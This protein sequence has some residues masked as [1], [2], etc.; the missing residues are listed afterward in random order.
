MALSHSDPLVQ[1]HRPKFLIITK[2]KHMNFKHLENYIHMKKNHL[3][4]IV[5]LSLV[6]E[7][8]TLKKADNNPVGTEK[9]GEK[10]IFPHKVHLPDKVQGDLTTSIFATDVQYIPLETNKNSLLRVVNQI[11]MNDSIIAISDYRKLLLFS[12]E[13]AF[14]S[15]LGQVAR[16]R[17]NIYLFLILS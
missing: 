11:R 12:K 14:L 17:A 16:G 5:I 4:V 9:A 13:G 2:F 7:G 10:I 6:A 1:R 8:C 15:R 3:L